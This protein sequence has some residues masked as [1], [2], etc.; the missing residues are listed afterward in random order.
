MLA[1]N[2]LLSDVK[3]SPDAAKELSVRSNDVSNR[4]SA[5]HHQKDDFN[6]VMQRSKSDQLKQEQIR[7]E[8]AKQKQQQSQQQLI[9]EQLKL[10][11]P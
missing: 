5:S 3:P 8:Q 1:N 9:R 2:M 7:Q 4:D 10:K 6:Q 11:I